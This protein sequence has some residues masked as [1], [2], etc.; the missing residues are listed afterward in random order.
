MSPSE[1]ATLL[2]EIN[3]DLPSGVDWKAGAHR[4]VQSYFKKSSREDVERYVMSKPLGGVPTSGPIDLAIEEAAE[5]LFN[6][7]NTLRLLRLPG[8]S[9]V[10]DVACGGGWLAHF[11]AR[12]NYDAYGF[13]LNVDFVDI[14]RRRLAADPLLTGLAGTLEERLFALDIEAE[15]LPACLHGTFDAAILESCLH[16]FVDP[17][18]ALSHIADG[19]AEGGVVVV[20]EGENRRGAIREEYLAVMREWHA[21]ER[22]YPR[23]LL[24]RVYRAAGL[25]HFEFL[26]A[27]NGWFSVRDPASV[28]AT[29]WL[30]DAAEARNFSVCAKTPEALRRVLPGYELGKE[31]RA[32]PSE[33]TP[34]PARLGILG[35]ISRRA[36]TSVLRLTGLPSPR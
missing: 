27:L 11:L 8:G 23:L 16:H 17:V 29:E 5:L 1:R 14:A 33:P 34:L 24:E 22:P 19:L 6:F 31:P 32:T 21:L 3:A 7:A 9:R 15:P 35:R 25:P 26:G 36:R 2:R 13:D 20:L 4:Y 28:R 12:M 10:L 18:T 30:L